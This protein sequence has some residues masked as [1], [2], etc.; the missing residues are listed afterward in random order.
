[1]QDDLR[2]VSGFMDGRLGVFSEKSAT[3]YEIFK[4]DWSFPF[5][6]AILD[7]VEGQ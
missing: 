1:M 4:K 2:N 7:V 5:C 6:T 3:D